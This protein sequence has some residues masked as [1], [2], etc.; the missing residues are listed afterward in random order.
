METDYEPLFIDEIL[1][2]LSND[3]LPDIPFIRIYH[4]ILMSLTESENEQHYHDLIETLAQHQD[5]FTHAE[6]RDMYIYAR[7]YCIKK[8]NLG[9]EEYQHQLFDLYDTL[10]ERGVLMIK[11]ELSQWD[12]MNIVT[13]SLRLNKLEYAEDFIY[14][15]KA[16][17]NATVRKNAFTYNLAYLNFYKKE[18]NV[19]L[20]KLQDVNFT[21][22]YYH[23]ET[24]ALTLRTYYELEE[25]IPLFSL[26]DAFAVYLRRNKKISE[27]H[28]K[29]YSNL[30]RLVKKMAKIKLGSKISAQKLKDEIYSTEQ[31]ASRDWLKAKVEELIK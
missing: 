30:I 6:Y 15:F 29:V 2:Y 11:G 1:R 7:N 12:F 26:C 3:E 17:L 27:Y 8:I 25:M 10:T 23:L 18:Y 9:R 19:T 21:N 28:R 5:A 13:L 24:K 20:N 4:K 22:P 16:K 14:G 31:T